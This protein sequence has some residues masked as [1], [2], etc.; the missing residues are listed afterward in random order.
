MSQLS[1]KYTN[2][3]NPENFLFF[4]RDI[5]FNKV[6]IYKDSKI[7]TTI[8]S[9]E[10]LKKGVTFKI[11]LDN[12]F[13]VRLLKKESFDLFVS[14]NSERYEEIEEKQTVLSKSNVRSLSR[15]FVFVLI[16]QLINFV[17]LS[18]NEN[19]L[20]RHM[21]LEPVVAI[22]YVGLMILP[23]LCYFV[24]IYLLHDN[25]G[26]VYFLGFPILLVYTILEV[27]NYYVL[28]FNWKIDFPWF[29]LISIFL[30]TIACL[31]LL[32]NIKRVLA[33]L[34]LNISKPESEVLDGV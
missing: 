22:Y 15:V 7:I 11:D 21:S 6:T 10:D 14:V 18:Q 9:V 5:E 1:R 30:K 32:F 13:Y 27:Y 29:I 17:I 20:L 31:I 34:K 3:S 19:L 24:T 12:E 28:R 16:I 2:P 33:N 23:I 26:K 25:R 8:T 4:T